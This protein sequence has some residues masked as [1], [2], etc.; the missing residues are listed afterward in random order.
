MTQVKTVKKRCRST[1]DKNISSKCKQDF[2]ENPE[3]ACEEALSTSNSVNS[4]T[5]SQNIERITES[6]S[7]VSVSPQTGDSSQMLTEI[8]SMELRLTA[9]IKEKQDKE[10]SDMEE[11]LSNIISTSISEAVKGI[12]SS[13]N[14]IVENNPVLQVHSTEIANLKSENS[15][16]NRWVQQLTMEQTRMKRQLVRIEDKNLG[17][18]LI[19]RGINEEHKETEQQI[20]HKIHSLLSVLMQGETTDK[21]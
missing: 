1:A 2:S 15:A 5:Q 16:L 3:L 12:Q 4:Q 20:C 17:R 19:F 13:L 11:R 14:T 8:K 6:M 10:M 21:N 7:T 18:S 9:S